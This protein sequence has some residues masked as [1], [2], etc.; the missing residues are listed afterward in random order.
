MQTTCELALN[1]MPRLHAEIKMNLKPKS[2][3]LPSNVAIC[4]PSVQWALCSWGHVTTIFLKIFFIEG[5]NLKNARNGTSTSKIPKWQSLRSL[6]LKSKFVR[7]FELLENLEY[8]YGNSCWRARPCS[9]ATFSIQ[10]F[11]IFLKF[12][13]S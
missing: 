6:A 5:Y 1:L 12:K 13:P 11:L 10:I 4:Q 7:Q 2:I 8:I 3:Y 9:P